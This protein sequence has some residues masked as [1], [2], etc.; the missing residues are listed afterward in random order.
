MAWAL[1]I[2]HHGGR[3]ASRAE[4]SDASR[5]V[6]SL[7]VD[8][9]AHNQSQGFTQSGSLFRAKTRAFEKALVKAFPA[10]SLYYATG[11]LL[12]SPSDIPGYDPADHT[13]EDDAIEAFAWWR[14]RDGSTVYGGI[15]Q[16]FQ[17]IA[18]VIKTE[19]PFDGVIG[20]SQGGCAAPMVASLLEPGRKA[21]FDAARKRDPEQIAYPEDLLRPDGS[22]LQP[23]MKFAV[24]YSGFAAPFEHYRGFY[25]PKIKTPVLHVLGSLDSIVTEERSRG[26][27]GVCERGDERVVIHPGAHVVPMGRGWL[28]KVFAFIQ[29]SAGDQQPG[30]AADEARVEDMDVPF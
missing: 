24:A 11:P 27:V 26:L 5:S 18:H 21:A 30:K 29:T 1:H 20:F 28:D 22:L 9:L 15:E 14:R 16:F 19:G 4:D 3:K 17:R 2:Q 23:P 25:E 6:R 12:L 8:P 7:L 10:S 13:T